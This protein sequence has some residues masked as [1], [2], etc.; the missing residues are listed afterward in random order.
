MSITRKNLQRPDPAT[1]RKVAYL[2]R[3]EGR[4]DPL[5][6]KRRQFS[7]QVPTVKEA[8][9]LE[10]DWTGEVARGTALDPSKTTVAELMDAWLTTKQGEVSPNSWRDYEVVIRLHLKPALGD[11][12]VQ[13]LTAASVQAQYAAWREAGRSPRMVRGCH[14][15]LSQALKQAVRHGIVSTNVCDSVSPPRLPTIKTVVWNREEASRFLDA[16]SDDSL[17]PLWH[18]L[19][20]E[21][22]R[23]GEGLGL[24]WRDVDLDR[25]TASIVQTV[26]PDKSNRGVAI[27]QRS[28]KTR[29][30]SRSVRLTSRTV[31]AL[32]EHR[33]IQAERRLA[34]SEWQDHDLIVS[35]S[36]GTPINPNNVSRS[37]AALIRDT[38]LP[39]I[40]VHDL[41]HSSAT[42]LLLAGVPAKVVSERLGHATVG[43]TLDLYSHVLPDM[44]DSAADAMDNLLGNA[45]SSRRE[46]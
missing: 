20:L 22:L 5:T 46:A 29:A 40:R 3:V 27:I 8:R 32:R 31:A 15:R 38:G 1:G 12:P 33:K 9:R 34:A 17:H 43:I 39:R 30:S 7:R 11:I 41:R 19:V 21:G 35:T 37:F 4:R 14:M 28:V 18:L 23:R 24:R 13:R 10:A 16:A 26:A 42:L 2:V 6:G 45:G 44:Q 25:G 36:K